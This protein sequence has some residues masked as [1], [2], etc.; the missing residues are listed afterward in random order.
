LD[1]PMYSESFLIESLWTITK[2]DTGCRLQIRWKV[3]Y[4]KTVW[5]K[6]MIEK[7]AKVATEEFYRVWAD[8]AHKE[9]AKKT[10]SDMKNRRDIR[11]SSISTPREPSDAVSAD[12]KPS[13]FKNSDADATSDAI[14]LPLVG[15]VSTTLLTMI[16]LVAFVL[17]SGMYFF[18]R[19]QVARTE[20]SQW[21]ATCQEQEDR[22]VFLQTLVG[23]M[24]L[25]YTGDPG[26]VKPWGFWKENG[27]DLDWRLGEWHEEIA[28]LQRTLGVALRQV[29]DV[30]E[31]SSSKPLGGS[32]LPLFS[33]EYD[34]TAIRVEG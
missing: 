32:S 14:E 11:I 16:L 6:S 22:L 26:V 1:I 17:L 21:E 7:N 23:H 9:L 5:V 31:Y 10:T 2:E 18:I 12:R 3:R 19:I 28:H 8:E 30:L 33:E 25:N 29:A 27:E 34:W 15:S 13:M 20:L 24:A 4:L